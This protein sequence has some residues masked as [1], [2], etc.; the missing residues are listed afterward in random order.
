L[1]SAAPQNEFDEINDDAHDSVIGTR[2]AETV[3]V[4]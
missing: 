3:K 2:K 1:A 4:R